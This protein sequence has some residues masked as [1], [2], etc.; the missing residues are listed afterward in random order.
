V[1]ENGLDYVLK[2]LFEYMIIIVCNYGVLYSATEQ[3]WPGSFLRSYP[4]LPILDFLYFSLVTLVTLGPGDIA[5]ICPY[6]KALVMSQIASGILLVFTAS[7][8]ALSQ[9]VDSKRI[10]N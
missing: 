4:S 6:V 3:L 7:G 8:V 10:S 2:L 1:K 5:V 9:A